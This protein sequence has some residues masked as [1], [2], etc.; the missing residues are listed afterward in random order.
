MNPKVVQIWDSSD[1]SEENGGDD[2]VGCQRH[3]LRDLIKRT[4]QCGAT[5]TETVRKYIGIVYS[6]ILLSMYSLF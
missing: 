6:C 5:C 3:G 2:D 4:N 1:E